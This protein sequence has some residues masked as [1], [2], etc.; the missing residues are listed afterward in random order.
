MW[1]KNDSVLEQVQWLFIVLINNWHHEDAAKWSVDLGQVLWLLVSQFMAC[2]WQSVS[3]YTV[4][5]GLKLLAV[6]TQDAGRSHEGA[7]CFFFCDFLYCF[8]SSLQFN[9]WNH[10]ISSVQST[11][12]LIR[13]LSA[14]ASVIV[15]EACHGQ[16]WMIEWLKRN[17]KHF[18][19]VIYIPYFFS[20]INVI[21]VISLFWCS[22]YFYVLYMEILT[23]WN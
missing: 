14:Y 9:S 1:L 11:V 5:P 23:I 20:K 21:I 12:S 8:Y 15:T 22:A 17:Q 18:V 4:S 13:W 7:Y 3:G 6:S 19:N 10:S 2:H 16:G